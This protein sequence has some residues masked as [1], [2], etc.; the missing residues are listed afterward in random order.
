MSTKDKFLTGTITALATPFRDGQV[1]YEDLKKLVAFQIKGGI[2]GLVP[3]GT[4]GESP[5]LNY[6]EHMDVIRFVVAEARRRVPVIAGTGSNSTHEAVEFTRLS[7]EAKADAM[8]VVAPYYNKPSQEGMFRHF[9]EIAETTDKPIILYSIPGR[10]GVEIG[11][12]LVERLRA[13]YPH[14]AWIKEA[15]GSVDRVDQ[16]KQALGDDLVVLSGDDSLTLPFMAV[17]AEGVISVASNLYVREISKMVQLAIANDF[18]KAAKIHRRLYPVFKNLFIEP[19]P[20][21]IK[22]ALARAGIIASPEVR[23]PLCEMSPANAKIL[24]QTLA[25]LD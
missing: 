4:T 20:V 1:S 23:S 10:C 2:N 9:S 6:E 21:P 15:G 12:G 11:V 24:E 17:G 7:H 25:A 5:T 14:V 19:N 18:R 3:M 8:L 22:V 13:K 16:L